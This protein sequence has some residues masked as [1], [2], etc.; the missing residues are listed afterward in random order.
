MISRWVV[1]KFGGTS[2]ADAHGYQTAGRI[3]RSLRSDGERVAVIASAMSGVTDSLIELVALAAS[4]NDSY[5]AKLYDLK[6][7][8]LATMAHLSLAEEQKQSL[9]ESLASD[10]K[11]IEEVLRGVWITGLPSEPIREFV[12]GHGELWSAQLLHAHLADCDES[13]CWLD[14]RK[15]LIVEPGSRTVN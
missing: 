12:C 7:K 13:S 3:L 5:L 8:H 1:H 4:Q 14:A 2:L 11:N 9:A 10:F 6:E 15:I